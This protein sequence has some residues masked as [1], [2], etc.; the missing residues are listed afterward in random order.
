MEKVVIGVLGGFSRLFLQIFSSTTVYGRDAFVEQMEEARAASRGVITVSNHVSIFDDPFTVA[1]AVPWSWLWDTHK[2]RRT[3]CATNRCFFHP[4]VA[5]IL[6]WGRVLPLARGGGIHQP[7]MDDVVDALQAGDW[8]HLF[9]EGTRAHAPPRLE[10]V[11]TG[12]GRLIAD[13]KPTPLVIPLV[14]L[15]ME[16]MVGRGF[17][18]P[19]L[20]L[21][22]TIAIGDP[23][24][25][26]D[27]LHNA[28]AYPDADALYAAIALRV[29]ESMDA[30]LL[31]AQ[32]LHSLRVVPPSSPPSPTPSPPAASSE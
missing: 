16:H 30:L 22:L 13:A 5:Q 9:P 7:Y 15:G 31:H 3:V 29:Q 21:D 26:D 17:I 8:I 32:A 28:H 19:N 14:H 1:A 12:V 4:V 23:I 11:R 25:F 2:L 6:T 18:V 20:G 24:S 10:P 27:I